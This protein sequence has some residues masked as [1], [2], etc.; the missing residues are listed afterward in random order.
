M[1][2]PSSYLQTIPGVGS[3][4]AQTII[5]EVG[6]DMT[7]FPSAGHLRS[8]AGLCPRMDESAGKRRSTRLRKGNVWLKTMLVQ[9]AWAAIRKEGYLRALFLRIRARQG[10]KK[11]IV[12]VAAA[13]LTA[14]HGILRDHEPYRDLGAE[15]FNR[16]DRQRVAS[17]LARRIRSLGYEIEMRPAA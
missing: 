11:A 2:K 9:C 15:H 5:A 16:H 6:D 14:V 13:I 10:S 12:A 3:T 1:L 8:W 7:R 17:R 4:A